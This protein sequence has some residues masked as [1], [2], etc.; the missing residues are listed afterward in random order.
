VKQSMLVETELLYEREHDG[1]N[2]II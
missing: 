2:K 1:R